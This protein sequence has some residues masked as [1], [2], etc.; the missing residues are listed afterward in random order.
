VNVSSVEGVRGF[1]R[2][3]VYGAYKAAL[4]HFTRS[5]AL[6]VAP[7]GVRV[8]AVAP[9]VTQTPQVDYTR[10]ISP[11]DEHRWSTW[12]PLGR[13]GTAAETADVVVFLASD[14][15]SFVT[16]QVVATDGGTLVA[17]G[18]FRTGDGRWTNRPRHP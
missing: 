5:L 18:W 3:P 6:E 17:G 8:N 9:D 1:P 7:R 14:L 16:G 15:A 4:I 12:V 13:F 10:L 2:D 11:E